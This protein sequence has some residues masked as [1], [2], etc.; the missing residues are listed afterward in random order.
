MTRLYRIICLKRSNFANQAKFEYTSEWFAASDIVYWRPRAAGYTTDRFVAGGDEA[1]N[2][3]VCRLAKRPFSELDITSVV[4][5]RSGSNTTFTQ[6]L[7]DIARD[8]DDW[9]EADPS[10]TVYV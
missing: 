8:A 1:S 9:T 7:D 4:R 2:G 5:D 3:I 6:A 10:T